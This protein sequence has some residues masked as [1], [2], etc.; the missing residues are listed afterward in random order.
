MKKEQN[1]QEPEQPNGKKASGL[2]RYTK[3]L[4]ELSVVIIG[5]AVTFLGSDWIS[6]RKARNDLDRYLRAVKTELEDNLEIIE[7]K[8]EFY[9]YTGELAH[10]L[11][12]D[13]PENLSR[14]TLLYVAE[15][16]DY[17]VFTHIFT[18]TYKTSAFEMLKSS[19]TMH[20][21]SDTDLFQ[22]IMDSYTQMGNIKDE[23]DNYMARKLNIIYESAM[24]QPDFLDILDKRSYYFFGI[25][26]DL[27]VIFQ[28]CADQIE[29][30]LAM[31]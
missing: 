11:M 1:I 5:V 23:S 29:E 27:D 15:K 19:G 9:G 6:S 20:L 25:H 22:A 17:G 31:L 21:I 4:R 10:Y 2:K 13:R 30:T 26:I 14:D 24:G 16:G 8:A 7:E 18:M 28:E 3:Y 12:S